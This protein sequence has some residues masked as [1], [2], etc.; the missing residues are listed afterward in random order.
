MV[1]RYSG[2][3]EIQKQ[4]KQLPISLKIGSLN[5]EGLITSG[6]MVD[7]SLEWIFSYGVKT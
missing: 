5:M 2:W 4:T 3:P 6:L 7:L 1:D